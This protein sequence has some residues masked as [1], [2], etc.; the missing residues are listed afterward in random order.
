MQG[1]TG[2]AGSAP[3]PGVQGFPGLGALGGQTLPPMPALPQM[4]A[5]SPVDTGASNFTVPPMPEIPAMPATPE[6][7]AIPPTPSIP[8]LSIPNAD[9]ASLPFVSP[10]GGL[11]SA[12][13]GG[14]EFILQVQDAGNF[15]T[16]QSLF[17]VNQ[18][19]GMFTLPPMPALPGTP[20]MPAMPATPAIP[21]L[22]SVAGLVIPGLGNL[23]Q[24]LQS[25]Q[26]DMTNQ[27]PSL[28][29]MSIWSS[30]QGASSGVA[31]FG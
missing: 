26:G 3:L 14:S 30:L 11:M 31:R 12:A 13:G 22:Q 21:S 27:V 6:I 28:S 15:Q 23:M 4:P 20:A 8:P 9:L 24:Q 2:F 19:S 16:A 18:I 17:D 7:P 1:F 29:A 25:Q 10:M 5:L